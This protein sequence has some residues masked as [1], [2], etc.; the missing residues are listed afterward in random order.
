M[1][2]QHDA[3]S[4]PLKRSAGAGIAPLHGCAFDDVAEMW[5]ACLGG[6]DGC[7]GFWLYWVE[8]RIDRAL[9]DPGTVGQTPS[10][11]EVFR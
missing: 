6:V 5:R 2:N 4:A 8:Q 1:I 7:N 11:A 3:A 10:S 9:R